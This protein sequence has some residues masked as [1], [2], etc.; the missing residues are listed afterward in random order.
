[1]NVFAVR[2]ADKDNKT[3]LDLAKLFQDPAVQK[4]FAKD[5]PE[6]VARD[7]SATKL[8]A[9]LATVEQDAKAAKQ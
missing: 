8:Q 6:A 1:V 7:E 9:E 5:L 2:D 3:Y 4:A